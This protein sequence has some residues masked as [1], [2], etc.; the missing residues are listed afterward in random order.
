MRHWLKSW[1]VTLKYG[2]PFT[3]RGRTLRHNLKDAFSEDSYIEVR[4]PK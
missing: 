1:W 2:S 4:R 3:K